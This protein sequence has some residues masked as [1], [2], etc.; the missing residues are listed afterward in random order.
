MAPGPSPLRSRTPTHAT[1]R[2]APRAAPPRLPAHARAEPHGGCSSWGSTRHP[3]GQVPRVRPCQSRGAFAQTYRPSA[4]SPFPPRRVCVVSGGT[5]RGLLPSGLSLRTLHRGGSVVGEVALSHPRGQLPG[6]RGSP[7]P[8]LR[9]LGPVLSSSGTSHLLTSGFCG[10]RS[11]ESAAASLLLA[12]LV[13]VTA[14]KI[15]L[16]CPAASPPGSKAEPL[17]HLHATNAEGHAPGCLS[18]TSVGCVL[19]PFS[20][21]SSWGR[22]TDL[23]ISSP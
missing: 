20:W 13:F 11:A 2:H 22:V 9:V 23:P 15:G 3:A 5:F 1:P 12:G 21:P 18:D 10:S 16:K 19:G 17:A 8:Q 4:R 7:R 6:W 14:V